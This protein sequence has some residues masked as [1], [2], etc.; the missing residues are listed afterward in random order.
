MLTVAV[1]VAG[2]EREAARARSAT[3][4]R[5]NCRRDASTG[6]MIVMD[7]GGLQFY[8]A[9]NSWADNILMGLFFLLL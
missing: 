3:W 4:R 5:E 8:A 2:D 6:G 9:A 7:L 1:V